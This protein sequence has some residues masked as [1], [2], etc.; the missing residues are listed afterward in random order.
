ME[1]LLGSKLLLGNAEVP[2]SSLQAGVVAVY[3]SAHW[4]GPC[5]AYTPQL[6]KVYERARAKG[7]A[8]EV[9]FV[10]SD[11]DDASFKEYFG[12]MPW[13]A[14]PYADRARQQVLNT[15][16]QVRGIPSLVLLDGATGSLLDAN[17]RGKVMQPD[18]LASLPRAADLAAAALPQPEGP[19]ALV[20]RHR[21]QD[22]HLSTRLNVS[23]ARGG[24]ATFD[25][26][27]LCEY[28]FTRADDNLQLKFMTFDTLRLDTCVESASGVRHTQWKSWSGAEA[29]VTCSFS[30]FHGHAT[31]LTARDCTSVQLLM[32]SNIF[33]VWLPFLELEGLSDPAASDCLAPAGVLGEFV[34]VVV[35]NLLLELQLQSAVGHLDCAAIIFVLILIY[36][37]HRAIDA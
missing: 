35:F 13:H 7:K 18:F 8:F 17:A 36:H 33:S 27:C 21:R 31:F 19:V 30:N 10:S 32:I 22:M 29:G 15:A 12:S 6:K 11:R 24:P 28:I 3:F 9:V 20:V 23:L 16:F 5:Q 2:S 37:V 14:V 1:G 26:K 25:K 4:C 34:V